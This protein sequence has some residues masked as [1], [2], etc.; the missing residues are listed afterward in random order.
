MATIIALLQDTLDQYTLFRSSLIQPILFIP[1]LNA[2]GYENLRRNY[3]SSSTDLPLKN[4]R[5]TCPAS[6]LNSGVN[7]GHNWATGFS[8]FSS[9]QEKRVYQ[10]PCSSSYQGPNAFSEP[11]TIALKNLIERVNPSLVLFLHQRASSGESRIIYPFTYSTE[12]L[13]LIS[14]VDADILKSVYSSMNAAVDGFNYTIGT[15][16]DSMKHTIIGS[17]IDWV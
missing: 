8:T 17:E 5:D 10:N 12:P 16:F 2:D 9:D 3:S 14:K 11:E 6:T 1:L 13:K 15:A 4:T 7:L